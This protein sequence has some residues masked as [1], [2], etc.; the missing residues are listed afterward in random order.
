MTTEEGLENPSLPLFAPPLVRLDPDAHASGI[1]ATLYR[2]A[3]PL[4]DGR[5][6]A[7]I[8]EGPLDLDDPDANPDL[9][10]AVLELA[11]D[12]HGAGPQVISR[13]V[14]VDNASI[15]DHDPEPVSV[16]YGG[17]VYSAPSDGGEGHTA[18]DGTNL[19]G[20]ALL[21]Y[22]G[23]P[24]VDAILGNLQP[25]GTK[26]IDE[27][28]VGVRL[29]ETIP[30]SLGDRTPI[31]PEDSRHKVTGA[32]SVS[33]SPHGPAR[34]LGE[35]PLAEDGTFQADV[36]AGTAVRLQGIDT[37]GMAVGNMHNRW[38]DFTGGQTM[39]QGI[40]HSN[41]LLYSAQCS[42]CH[43]AHDGDPASVFI[44]PDVMTTAT[45][46]LSRFEN[47]DPRRPL[48]APVLG[49]LTRQYVDFLRDVQPIL[50]ESCLGS[51]CHSGSEPAGGLSL[52]DS[53][54]TWFSDAYESLLQPGDKGSGQLRFVDAGTGS[55]RRS[56]LVEVLLGEELEA[57]ES[58]PAG[59]E[60]HPL[61]APLTS[62]E[63]SVLTRWIDLGATFSGGL[64]EGR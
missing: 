19:M 52:T 2:D 48:A 55:A 42:V 29:I 7:T 50:S 34:I 23:L 5:I 35:L 13:R 40:T 57:D 36:P 3:A 15:A 16:R 18:P 43:G 32:T 59:A 46:T 11:E 12:L 10:I 51:G 62:A 30:T 33:L 64:E 37:R 45:V 17:P 22:N 26:E 4:P 1:T 54:T 8:A 28:I 63:L 6:L 24:M 9:A 21:I 58:L 39:K 56:Y 60:P 41:E 53:P 20:R 31:D 47:R 61:G 25:A 27:R 38:F 49:D 44:A 14:L